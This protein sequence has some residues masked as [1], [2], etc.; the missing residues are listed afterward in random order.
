MLARHTAPHFQELRRSFLRVQQAIYAG[1]ATRPEHASEPVPEE[2][3]ESSTSEAFAL[4]T[5]ADFTLASLGYN[6]PHTIW[7]A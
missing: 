3:R 6:T 1:E 2:R 5:R 7:H 4:Q